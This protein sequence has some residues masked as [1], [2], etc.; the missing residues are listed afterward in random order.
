MFMKPP[1]KSDSD[2]EYT[3]NAVSNSFG[4]M[5]YRHTPSSIPMY[6]SLHDSRWMFNFLRPD[7]V[8]AYY[9]SKYKLSG[10]GRAHFMRRHFQKQLTLIKS[11]MQAITN[12]EDVTFTPSRPVLTLVDCDC[13]FIDHDAIRTLRLDYSDSDASYVDNHYNDT[14]SNDNDSITDDFD[15]EN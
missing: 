14:D 5:R 12:L 6:D 10:E 8:C 4:T 9:T 13:V 7:G 2:S 3:Y 1:S 15:D 11:A